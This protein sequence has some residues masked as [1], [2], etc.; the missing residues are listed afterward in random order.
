M[1]DLGMPAWAVSPVVRLIQPVGG[2]RGTEVTVTLSGQRLTDIE[3]ILF[4]QPGIA[5][6]RI[7]GGQEP[8]A[9]VTFKIPETAAGLHDFR[10]RNRTGLSSLKSFSVGAPKEL[11]EVGTEWHHFAKP[12][13]I[14]MKVTVKTSRARKISITLKS[15][16]MKGEHITVEVQGIRL[17]AYARS[18][19]TC[20]F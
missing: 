8:R 15:C 3:E 18:T 20:E 16:A 4:Y 19:L 7:V 2:Q 12:Q 13:N 6:T 1:V 11:A 14:D 10:V 5:V 9:V 17:G